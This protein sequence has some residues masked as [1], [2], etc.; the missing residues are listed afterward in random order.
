[1]LILR[2]LIALCFTV[3]VA[4]TGASSS[5]GQ[6]ST[7]PPAPVYNVEVVVFRALGAVGSPENWAVQTREAATPGEDDA[8]V[9]AA[10]AGAARLIATVPSTEFKLAEIESR[11]RASGGYQPIAHAAWQQTPSPW[12][13]KIGFPLDKLGISAAG[14]S[15]SIA[16]ER[17]Q[18]LHLGFDLNYAPAS[19]PAGLSA[20]PGT[21]FIL[22]ESRRVKF[23]ERNYFDHPAFGVIAIVTPVQTRPGR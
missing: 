2:R 15:G 23:F 12:G 4:L 3:G 11:L 22:N 10:D 7:A 13:S 17:G 1:M 21:V 16:L 8:P 5:F 18:Y 9:A 20:G 14:L 6:Q 19:V